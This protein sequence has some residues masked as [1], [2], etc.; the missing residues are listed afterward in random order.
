MQV[1]CHHVY[2]LGRSRNLQDPAL[3]YK[4]QLPQLIPGWAM[5]EFSW[6]IK[7]Q[8]PTPTGWCLLKRKKEFDDA[9]TIIS[10][11]GTCFAKL[12]QV[13]S[14]SVTSMLLATWP[15]AL[16]N[17]SMPVIWRKVHAC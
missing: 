9:R 4:T 17:D 16:G 1:L 13:V 11:S 2:D 6:G 3:E 5:Q 14:K 12:L 7:P 8:A 15:E 10:Y